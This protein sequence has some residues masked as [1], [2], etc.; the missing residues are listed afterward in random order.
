ME[1]DRGSGGV[2][3]HGH[4]TLA[5]EPLDRVHLGLVDLAAEIGDGGRSDREGRLG[6]RRGRSNG[7]LGRSS[8]H[9]DGFV[10]IRKAIRPTADAM[11]YD[12]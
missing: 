10:L 8:G 9:S 1:V 12:T 3:G 6:G 11:T 7:R 5:E 4:A 2:R